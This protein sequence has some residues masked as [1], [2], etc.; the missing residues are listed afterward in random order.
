[1]TR[2]TSAWSSLSQNEKLKSPMS[3]YTGW[4]SNGESIIYK[5]KW[6]GIYGEARMRYGK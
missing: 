1:M 4:G 5:L 3:Q 2:K 6:L